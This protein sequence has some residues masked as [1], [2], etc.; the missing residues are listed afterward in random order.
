[1]KNRKLLVTV[2]L[3]F[4]A[5]LFAQN[6]T[7][8]GF[9]SS[10]S[11]AD[12][13]TAGGATNS[14]TSPRTGV[15]SLAH[16]TST[17]ATTQAHTNANIIS[18]PNLSY[19]HV[20]AWAVGS[21]ANADSSIGGTLNVTTNNTAFPGTPY[22]TT[23]TRLTYVSSQNTSGGALNF[24][25]RLRSRSKTA[26]VSTTIYWDDVIMYTSTS[27]T[28]DLTKPTAPTVFTTGATLYNSVTFSWTNGS[29]AATGIQNTIILRTTN[30]GA[31]TP[32]M[33]DQGVYAITGSPAS[34]GPS[35]V[36]TDWTVIST[37]VASGVTSYTDTS[38][39]AGTTYLYAVIHRDLAYNYST[40]L[41]SG[42]IACPPSAITSVQTGNWSNPATWGGVVPTS[43]TDAIIA[44]GHVVTMDSA[45]YNTRNIGTFTTV[46][47]GGT[48]ATG[49]FAY[50]NNGTTNINGTGTFRLDNSGSVTG[51]DLVYAG[52]STL[53]IVTPITISGA[54]AAWPASSSPYNVSVTGG[55]L[56]IN[57]GISR[58]VPGTFLAASAV[59]LIP[60]S[61]LTINGI[62][63]INS[64]GNFAS[65]APTY[66]N[67]ST[68]VYNIGGTPTV[69]NEWSLLP[70]APPS[71]G[72]GTP[73]NVTI[74][75]GTI[76][77]MP[78]STRGMAGDLNIITG[79]LTLNASA[80][81]YIGGN[82]SRASGA[83]FTPGARKVFF[84]SGIANTTHLVTVTG[85]GT[86][87][88]N[89]VEIQFTGT[90]KIATGTNIIVTGTNGLTLNSTN[91]TSTIDLNGRTMTVSGGGNLG[92]STGARK[93]TST[94]A[95]GTFVVSTTLLTLTLGG[96]GTLTTDTNTIVKL[97][98]GFNP[99]S[100]VLTVYGILQL[101][102]GGFISTNAP[103]YG[104]ASTLS[105]TSGSSYTRSL[106][107]SAT[108]GTIETTA[109]FPNNVL[110]TNSTTLNYYN[111]TYTG[112]KA[113]NGKLDIDAGAALS[114]GATTTG[115]ALTVPG[116][117]TNAGSITLGAA[118]GDDLKIGGD[119]AN[120]GL[121]TFNGNSRAIYFTKLGTQTVS[122]ATALTIPF[123][124]TSAGTTVQLLCDVIIS[125]S[126][127]GTNVIV[128]G[129]G[130]V[131]DI[132]GKNLTIGS[133]G[134]PG[135]ISGSGS[136]KGS[137]IPTTATDSNLT[138]LGTGSIGTISFTSDLNLGTFT[139]NRQAATIG[140]VMGSA[141]SI[142]TSLALTNGLIDLGANNLTLAAGATISGGSSNSYVLAYTTSGG[143]LIKAFTAAGSFTYPIGDNTTSLDYS[144]ATL[145]FTG[146][147][148]A[149]TVGVRVV[150]AAHP[151]IGAA[152]DYLT[153][154]WQVLVSGV[155]PTSYTF[156]GTYVAADIVG[157][158]SASVPGCWNGS[159]WTDVGGT[160]IGSNLCTVTGTSF[161]Y[162]TNEFSAKTGTP[163]PYFRSAVAGSWAT[164]SNWQS[165]TDNATWITSAY[166]PDSNATAITIRNPYNITISSGSVTADDITI[167]PSA[168]LT[169]SGGTFT[170]NNGAAAIDMQVNGSFTN[171]GGTFTQG[172]SGIAFAAAA[173]YNHATTSLTL[174]TA[175]WNATSTCNI[176]GLTI[177]SPTSGTT[178]F[179]QTF[180]NFTWNN[181]GQS[182]TGY[183]NIEKSSFAVVGTLTVGPSANNLL[184]FGNTG[185]FTNTVNKIVVTGGIL[186]CAGGANVTLTVTNDISVSGG[187][188][189]VSR[190][191][192]TAATSIGTDLSI[193]GTGV[194]NV[195]SS[196][197]SPST[198]L[199]IVRDLLISGSD[200]TLN[201][202]STSS[203][204]V[205]TVNVGRDFTCSSTG[206]TYAA[207]DFGTGA[208]TNNIINI[209]RN[210]DKSSTGSF[211]TTSSTQATGFSFNGTGTQTFSYAGN[212]SNWTSY[213]VQSGSTVQ[214]NSNL[215]LGINTNPPSW[216]TVSGTLNFGTNSI[217]AGNTTDPRF[218]ANSGGT[219]ISSNTGGFGGT[220]ATGSI[221]SFGGVGS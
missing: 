123:V 110:I 181:A 31:S 168:T 8:G 192:G 71:A 1:M 74:Q 203:T 14:S 59:A 87:T 190:G 127:T 125:S 198:T 134:N 202:E 133:T 199:T 201:L 161:P 64:G 86:E 109:G 10:I 65:A 95:N 132:N 143:Q 196:G 98:Q 152:T 13:T 215:T 207:V 91:A 155:T 18:V 188:L 153:R 54:N 7:N 114:F 15:Y 146:G 139:M 69:G 60:T 49:A 151:Q 120:T 99:G 52:T 160:G 121:G 172:A 32:V 122:S 117:V 193:S 43:N 112:A 36:S 68:L 180:G 106:E 186:N 34:S 118:L 38:V 214:L 27:N 169:V 96:A 62:C 205:A 135:T 2:V 173:T 28:P 217:I 141:L 213:I 175:T 3:L 5:T 79:N 102:S 39:A 211:Q 113:I 84:S 116:N 89:T 76:L 4:S 72:L 144:P 191:A 21:T 70:S 130:S 218:I 75:N 107:F 200:P 94:L 93:I 80:D 9:E 210:F 189:N 163:P 182:G 159:S 58:T 176:T 11:G 154:Y 44:S 216:F 97:Q 17:T 156:A 206:T 85:G 129:A 162:A 167:D 115:G 61:V 73:Q 164:A 142:K 22:G 136:F 24:T 6:P 77:T 40:A 25:S 16:T 157:T 140:C 221:Q 170:L 220:T 57:A 197:S 194:V 83:G 66:G 183:L 55:G 63:Q 158:E 78:A 45:S 81:F 23:L 46:N 150:D 137:I 208:T 166:V 35:T 108:T 147:S 184:S 148:Y 128:F 47:S 82:W 219:L 105:Y 119:Y 111:A 88:F 19:G 204:G 171:S 42:S 209:T 101:D 33:N 90:L 104:S 29:D 145:T 165:S 50:N 187:F 12:W 179:G 100:S 124:V 177:S 149:G 212:N 56:T 20:I 53:V 92:W 41:V 138:L 185:T 30:T 195:I 131:I 67:A 178:S 126:A 48:L 26:T 103:F 174:P 51:N 37:S